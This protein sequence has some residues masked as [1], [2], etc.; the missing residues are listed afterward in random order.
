MFSGKPC[1]NRH[2][3]GRLE[4]LPC[5]GHCGYPVTH[6]WRHTEHAIFFQAKGMHDHPRPEAK[7]TSEARRTLGSGRRV[8][9]L[10]VVLAKEAALGNKV[11]LHQM[12]LEG[13]SWE[14]FKPKIMEF[15]LVCTKQLVYCILY[16]NILDKKKLEK[17]NNQQFYTRKFIVLS[18]LAL[19]R[20]FCKFQGVI[21]T[22]QQNTWNKSF[23]K[24]VC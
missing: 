16:Y 10:A 6:F 12:L 3:T 18:F 1:P 8:R 23:L 5:R 9:G 19:P 2:C 7:T 24:N 22:N 4:I 15:L 11:S 21:Y 20:V 13:W 14:D 17:R